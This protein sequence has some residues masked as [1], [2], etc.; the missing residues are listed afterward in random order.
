MAVTAG[1]ALP[2]D[3]RLPIHWNAAGEVDGLTG[4]WTALLMPV[5]FAVLLLIIFILTIRT[6]PR[7]EAMTR[8]AGLLRA[9]WVGMF[10][11]TWVVELMVL[12]VAFAWRVPAVRL[13]LIGMGLLLVAMGD[14]LGK[15]R[16]MRFIGIRTPWTLADPDVWIATH[17]L[18]GKLFVLAGASFA[19]VRIHGWNWRWN[20]QGPE[21]MIFWSLACVLSVL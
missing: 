16:P 1:L 13:L 15:S 21:F 20:R 14:Q 7:R 17:R 18:G 2:P 12:S 9:V 6:E 19:V 11:I 5:G 10:G 8:S 3:I 4:K